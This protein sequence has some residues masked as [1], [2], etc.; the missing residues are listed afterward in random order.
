MAKPT[1]K[2]VIIKPARA[3]VTRSAAPVSVRAGRLMSMP[4]DGSATRKLNSTVKA[5][6]AGEMRMDRLPC[7]GRSA[8]ELPW[9]RGTAIG[10]RASGGGQGSF[11]DDDACSDSVD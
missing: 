4:K 9:R 3:G 7:P 1:M 5:M 6:E 8:S 10:I 2:R 11:L